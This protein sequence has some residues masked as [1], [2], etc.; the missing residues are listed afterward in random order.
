MKDS[1]YILVQAD[2]GESLMQRYLLVFLL[3]CLL[4]YFAVPRLS[5]TLD[6]ISG[7]YALCWLMLAIFVIAGNLSALLFPKNRKRYDT[8]AKKAVRRVRG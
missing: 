6:H 5:M 4:L 7:I 1:V 2:K 8:R 3:A